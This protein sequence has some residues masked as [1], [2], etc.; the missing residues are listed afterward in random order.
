VAADAVRGLPAVA[1]P[2]GHDPEPWLYDG[3]ISM[4]LRA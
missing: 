2:A 1:L 4:E 3:R